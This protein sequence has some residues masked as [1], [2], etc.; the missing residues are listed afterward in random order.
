MTI[1]A[2][3]EDAPEIFKRLVAAFKPSSYDAKKKDIATNP[4]T[5]IGVRIRPLSSEEVEV[6]DAYAVL[7]RSRAESVV[8]LH[9]LKMSARGLRLDVSHLMPEIH[10]VKLTC[11]LAVVCISI[12]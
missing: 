5:I 9:E 1:T 4:D 3:P 12:G 6:N 7:P 8:D 10:A 11:V 2:L